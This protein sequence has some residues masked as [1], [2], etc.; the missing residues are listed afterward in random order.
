MAFDNAKR[1]EFQWKILKDQF[2]TILTQFHALATKWMDQVK[3]NMDVPPKLLAKGNTANHPNH[4][5]S[6]LK[7]LNYERAYVEY[8][9]QA[10]EH[11]I[12]IPMPDEL[13]RRL[14]KTEMEI[15][16]QKEFPKEYR[17][18]QRQLKKKLRQNPYCPNRR[19]KKTV[20]DFTLDLPILLAGTSMKS[21]T[22]QNDVTPKPRKSHVNPPKTHTK[23]PSRRKEPSCTNIIKQIHGHGTTRMINQ[24]GYFQQP[25][26]TRDKVESIIGQTISN[27]KFH[28]VRQ[29]LNNETRKRKLGKA[30]SSQ[31]KRKGKIEKENYFPFFP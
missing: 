27:K 28:Q 17:S 25:F 30:K 20:D 10:L 14:R 4:I 15:K 23:P 2:Q 21:S 9:I 16:F 12:Q 13:H 22:K 24:H 7:R 11:N 26:F 3:E 8:K 6:E 29:R 18:F 1:R 19:A 31:L 5:M